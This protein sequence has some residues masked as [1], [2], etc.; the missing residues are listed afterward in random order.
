MNPPLRDRM[1]ERPAQVVVKHDRWHRFVV[2]RDL[3]ARGLYI[4]QLVNAS[5]KEAIAIPLE[6]YDRFRAD[7][8][9]FVDE[10][11][12]PNARK[13]TELRFGGRV[14]FAIQR[15]IHPTE[16]VKIQSFGADETP[17]HE[18]TMEPTAGQ[19]LVAAL[20]HPKLDHPNDLLIRIVTYHR[21]FS[22]TFQEGSESFTSN[23]QLRRDFLSSVERYVP[24]LARKTPTAEPEEVLVEPA[25]LKELTPAPVSARKHQSFRS[26]L[27]EREDAQEYQVDYDSL[28]SGA[29]PARRRTSAIAAPDSKAEPPPDDNFNSFPV[30]LFASDLK[31]FDKIPFRCELTRDDVKRLRRGFLD[32]RDAAFY[33]GFEICDC[34]F[35]HRKKLQTYRFPLYYFP[36]RIVESGREAII[37]PLEGNRFYL[38]HFA[39]ANLVESY[40]PTGQGLKRLT[41]LLEALI[42]HQFTT[43][44]APDRIRIARMLPCGTEVFD[45]TREI[46]LG[47]PGEQGKGGLLSEVKVR[48]IECDLESVALYK[49]PQSSSPITRALDE[50]LAQILALA[51][52]A[53][54]GF[55]SSLLARSLAA[56]VTAGSETKFSDT[57]S[58]HGPPTRAVRT[59]LERLN[60][61]DLVLL[62]GPPGTGK[63]YSIANLVLHCVA[64]RKRLLVVSDQAAAIQA[65]A[66]QI[67]SYVVGSNRDSPEG[68]QLAQLWRLAIKVV[69]ELPEGVGQLST[70]ARQVRRM[71]G[72]DA[73]KELDWPS[74]VPDYEAKL[75]SIDTKI[76]ELVE[77]ID[78]IMKRRLGQDKSWRIPSV[79]QK[80]AHPRSEDEV[81]ELLEQAERLMATEGLAAVIQGFIAS[82]E[83]L[84]ELG[85]HESYDLFS[86]RGRRDVAV[87]RLE[88]T[89]IWLNRLYELN[90]SRLDDFDRI[91]AGDSVRSLQASLR[92]RWLEAYPPDEGWTARAAR[93]VRTLTRASQL[94]QLVGELI[95]LVR[96]QIELWERQTEWEEKTWEALARL[97]L[98]LSP[99]GRESI[100]VSLELLMAAEEHSEA[101]ECVHEM[102]ERIAK[103]QRDRDGLVRRQ[104]LYGLGEIGQKAF[105]SSRGGGTN[106]LTSVLATLDRLE[107]ATSWAKASDAVRELQELLLEVFPIWICRKQAV[108]F[109]LPCREQSFDLVVVDEATQCRVDDAIPLLFRGKKLMA[110]GDERQTVLA[111]NSLIDDYLFDDFELDEHLRLAQARGIKGGGSHLFGLV[112]RIKQ[113]SVMLDEHYRCPPD[114]IEFSNQY[115]YDSQLRIMQ[116]KMLGASSSVIVDH[117]ESKITVND[118]ERSGKYKGIETGMIDRFFAYVART[119]RR[120]ERESGHEVNP[121]T[122][123]A[124]VYFL[125][126]NEPYVKDAKGDL[127]KKLPRGGNILDGAG[128]A[129]QGKERDYIFYLWDITRYN[130]AVFRQGDDETKRKG[131]LNVLMSRPKRRAYHFLHRD[132]DQLKHH[133]TSISDYLWRARQKNSRSKRPS[134]E[135]DS[136]L[137]MKCLLELSL[138][139]EGFEEVDLQF[140]VPIGDPMRGVDLM[141]LPPKGHR[142][143]EPSIG[144]VDLSVFEKSKT[145]GQDVADYFF[146]LQRAAPS[147]LPVFGFIHE[148]A[149]PSSVV[150]GRLLALSRNRTRG[151]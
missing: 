100:D 57:L 50:D 73:S 52:R 4:Y 123:V 80:S 64:T 104:F 85:F 21:L 126:K 132:F 43:R 97:H 41:E 93:F 142:A 98:S 96:K 26:R 109:L 49:T 63:T 122:D 147:V 15:G 27:G 145:P 77:H 110:V 121:E 138:G 137:L 37:H 102:L 23:L 11:D 71:L 78:G 113:A 39:L 66:E 94:Q 74:P 120:I 89:L 1:R 144:V 12:D 148:F 151:K 20:Y 118:R 7:V 119:I 69:D 19:A 101:Y 6:L 56:Q 150:V 22:A 65:L 75:S 129:L 58:M 13:R 59:L 14:Y 54:E 106:R 25:M 139:N 149:R 79:A 92:T 67:H 48:A 146:Q 86:L 53:P 141:W 90:P 17:S 81:V 31:L 114:I 70:W 61:H 103:L 84:L 46:L 34:I 112:K 62:E 95:Q 105:A 72:V 128:A 35:E 99:A 45:R 28:F 115:V 108:A 42:N 107:S 3:D 51:K 130:M 76:A 8:R 44:G 60:N 125:L 127:L 117:S 38:N 87:R 29:S 116:W 55:Q 5:R 131:E 30:P 133:T 36:V 40:A 82:R 16:W 68:R 91:E 111:K 9:T 124:I 83:R 143:E 32:D 33:L 18:I 88:E 24:S 2:S 47:L 134:V 135:R 140:G 10:L 136:G